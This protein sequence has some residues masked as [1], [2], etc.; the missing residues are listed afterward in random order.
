LLLD[1]ALPNTAAHAMIW[2]AIPDFGVCFFR[3]CDALLGRAGMERAYG[4]SAAPHRGASPAAVTSSPK[5]LL[6]RSS[7]G[8]LLPYF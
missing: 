8:L 7:I 2:D 6:S 4:L 1:A 3:R 5:F